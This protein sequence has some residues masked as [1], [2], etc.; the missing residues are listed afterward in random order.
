MLCLHTIPKVYEYKSESDP[1]LLLIS[2]YKSHDVC[3]FNNNHLLIH[4]A[5]C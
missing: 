2:L 5:D 3:R 4:C 1:I